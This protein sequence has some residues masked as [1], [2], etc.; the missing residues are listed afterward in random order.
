VTVENRP[1]I[2]LLVQQA[3]RRKIDLRSPLADRREANSFPALCEG[4]FAELLHGVLAVKPWA[5]FVSPPNYRGGLIPGIEVLPYKLE[6]NTRLDR[7]EA[8]ETWCRELPQR[9]ANRHDW[10]RLM[11]RT[12][13]KS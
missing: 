13:T 3:S 7:R 1:R 5:C 9:S 4:R 11:T 10:E 6:L 2:A 12:A 8:D